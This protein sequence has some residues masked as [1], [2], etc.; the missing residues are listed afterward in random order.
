LEPIQW[1]FPV[2]GSVPYKGFFDRDKALA[3]RKRL[4][5]QGLDVS[6]RNPGGW[7]TL[8]W[9]NDPILSNMLK[10]SDGDLAE[11]IIHEMVHATI[12]VKDSV[13]FNENLASFIGD[14]AAYYFLDYKYGKASDEYQSYVQGIED[15][16]H[17]YNH[18]LRGTQ[19]LDSLY[20]SLQPQE[21]LELKK[22]KKKRMIER[23]MITSDTLRLHQ[24]R[25]WNKDG[26][27][28]NNT[29]FMSYRLYHSRKDD[30]KSQ[31]QQFGH[32]KK[33]IRHL[34]ETHPYL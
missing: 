16:R 32:L 3:E 33:Y 4:E 1:K 6:V 30:F 29:Y 9:F 21:S 13:D 24:P 19:A 8:G 20:Q 17:Y 28:P 22:E 10:R 18:I 34:S 15:Y 23:I 14:T 11:L 25:T 5:E 27:I 31:L 2:V 26:R 7:S 12:F